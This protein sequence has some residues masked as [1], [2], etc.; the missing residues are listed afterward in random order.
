M[1][2]G[3]T[4]DSLPLPI[5]AALWDAV[6]PYAEE[7]IAA[8]FA[9]RLRWCQRKGENDAFEVAVYLTVQ[10]IKDMDETRWKTG[11]G[12]GMTQSPSYLSNVRPI[13][14]FNDFYA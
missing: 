2:L 13:Y 11:L 12:W 14:S 5:R 7:S 9:K 4:F 8:A 3:H 1:Y 10:M 6:Q